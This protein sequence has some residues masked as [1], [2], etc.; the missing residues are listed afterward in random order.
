MGAEQFVHTVL[1]YDDVREAFREAR[2]V[3]AWDHGH[4]GYT[5]T[6]AEKD[7]Y[8]VASDVGLSYDDASDLAYRLMDWQN[9]DPR[10]DDKWGPAGAIRVVGDEGSLPDRGWLFFGWASS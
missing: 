7:S 2:E 10:F 6:I 4:G 8:L 1:G 5:G 3:A 9:A